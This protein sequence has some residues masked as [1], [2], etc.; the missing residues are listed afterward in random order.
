MLTLV[1]IFTLGLLVQ[2][3]KVVI[4]YFASYKGGSGNALDLNISEVKSGHSNYESHST[5]AG[6]FD[7][8]YNVVQNEGITD[9]RQK[10][11]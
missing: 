7:F 3:F 1:L 4:Q 9:G 11:P 2:G 8:M 5:L 6:K 10:S